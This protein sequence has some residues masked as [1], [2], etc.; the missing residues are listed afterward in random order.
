[1]KKI[2]F[3]SAIVCIVAFCNSCKKETGSIDCYIY[4]NIDSTE[5]NMQ[6]FIDDIPRGQVPYLHHKPTCD[7]TELKSKTLNLVLSYG[8]HNIVCKDSTGTIKN[9]SYVKYTSKSSGGGG[10]LGG[11]EGN[12]NGVCA[13]IRIMY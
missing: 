1:M 5:K 7:S 2:V 12:S 13:I 10:T 3:L 11:V 8:K 4:Q 9:M 6:L